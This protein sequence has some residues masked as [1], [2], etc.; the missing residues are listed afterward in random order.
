MLSSTDNG[1]TYGLTAVAQRAAESPSTALLQ[2]L[3]STDKRLCHQVL[4]DFLHGRTS[5]PVAAGQGVCLPTDCSKQ[6]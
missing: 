5:N 1:V 4:Y 3:D 2:P 6:L